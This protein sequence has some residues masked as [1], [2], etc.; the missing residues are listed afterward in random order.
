MEAHFLPLGLSNSFIFQMKR[1][2]SK[3]SKA[4]NNI[5]YNALLYTCLLPS[6]DPINVSF[7]FFFLNEEP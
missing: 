6:H 4:P 3:E 1:L 5:D 2:R 7:A